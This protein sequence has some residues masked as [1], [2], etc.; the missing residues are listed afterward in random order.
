M[1]DA[2]GA[3]EVEDHQVRQRPVVEVPGDALLHPRR[4][5]DV[6]ERHD[7]IVE[8]LAGGAQA[9][10]LVGRHVDEAREVGVGDAAV[11]REDL[12]DA[13]RQRRRVG[14]ARPREILEE[15][16]ADVVRD[17][18]PLDFLGRVRRPPAHDA[19]GEARRR[20]HV[21]DGRH[22]ARVA[23]DRHLLTALR[24]DLLEIQDLVDLRT[25]AGRDRR[26][27]DRREHRHVALQRRRVA[28]G[29]QPLPVRHLPFRGEPVEQLP[30]EP[31][32]AEP[33]DRRA[34]A[35]L[36]LL[37]R[38]GVGRLDGRDRRDR[39]RRRRRRGRGPFG[40]APAGQREKGERGRA[41][42]RPRTE[43]HQR[44][45]PLPPMTPS[46]TPG[47]EVRKTPS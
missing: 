7:R 29:G 33:D 5:Q 2:V 22:R 36:A 17:E 16:R 9:R 27:D 12:L 40:R 42:E 20:R 44:P 23:R 26:P 15:D 31:V 25:H 11:P 43:P 39:G 32:E 30:V 8:G 34:P 1:A 35:G 4:A 21:P 13:G 18:E 46:A 47:S 37:P 14:D 10:D 38:P 28:F 6:R 19:D 41:A 45:D 24:V 3:L